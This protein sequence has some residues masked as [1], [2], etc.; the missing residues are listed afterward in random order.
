MIEEPEYDSAKILA[1]VTK[2][3]EAEQARRQ[4]EA[5]RARAQRALP[6]ATAVAPAIVPVEFVAEP[7]HDFLAKDIQPREQIL[8]PW[9]PTQGIAMLYAYRGVGKTFAA[10][11]IGYAVACGSSYLKWNAP[12]PRNVLYIDGEMPAT[13]MQERLA[14]IAAKSEAEP[15]A[16]FRIITPDSQPM[17]PPNIA[18]PLHQGLLDELLEGVDLVIIDNVSTLVRSNHGENDE[19]SWI[20]MQEWAL[21]QRAQGRSVLIVHHAGKGGRQRGTS[22]RE[23]VV[24]TSLVLKHPSDYDPSQG[25]LFEVH[26]EKSRGFYGEDAKPFQAN[27][28]ESGEWTFTDIEDTTLEKVVELMGLDLSQTE[29][30]HELDVNKSTVSRAVQRAKQNGLLA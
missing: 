7:I 21:R 25:A 28:L 2:P 1:D 13:A 19:Q 20:P 17:G 3:E 30:A 29:I 5:A 27:L 18:N 22:K 8:A 15:Q 16:D 12:K 24:D 6:A 9:L 10:L 26:Y 14:S 4:L 23:D 11:N